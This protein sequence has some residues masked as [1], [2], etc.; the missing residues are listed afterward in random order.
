M[1]LDSGQR[2]TANLGRDGLDGHPQ[3]GYSPRCS[4]TIRTARSR[5]SGENLFNLLMA[6]SSQSVEP[7]RNRGGS[8]K[9]R[10]LALSRRPGL[11]AATRFSALA[12]LAPWS[13]A[14]TAARRVGHGWQQPMSPAPAPA[15]GRSPPS[16][17]HSPTPRC[18]PPGRRQSA[19]LHNRFTRRAAGSSAL[20]S[21][22]T[23]DPRR[24]RRAHWPPRS[25][26]SP[27]SGAAPATAPVPRAG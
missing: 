12:C 8:P 1:N 10:V 15:S 16:H 9:R 14:P 24:G 3:R 17:A 25:A 27:A 19:R 26:G 21:R 18:A 23:A 22:F 13:C 2:H 4:C 6:Q 20:L 5:T 7:L 11:A